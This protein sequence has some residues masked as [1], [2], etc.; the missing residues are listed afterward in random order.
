MG[1][2]QVAELPGVGHSLL[3]HPGFAI[4]FRPRLPGMASPE[5]PLIQ[6]VLRFRAHSSASDD[7]GIQLQPGSK[8]A[9]HGRDLGLLSLMASIDKPFGR[10]RLRWKKADPFAPAFKDIKPEWYF[11]FMFETLKLVPGGEIMGMEFEA[12]PILGFGLAALLMILVP[13]LDRGVVEKGRSPWF[14]TVGV[15]AI[16]YIVGM[17]AWG[18]KSLVPVVV[19]IATIVLIGLMSLVTGG[20]PKQKE[21]KR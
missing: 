9:L 10:G 20:P 5:E 4:F 2:P 16:V 6:T 1:V 14:T 17:T 11:M 21:G 18:Y 7:E 12:I 19:V 15:V 3:D 13:F 8:V